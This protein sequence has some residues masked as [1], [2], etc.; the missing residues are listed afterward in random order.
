MIKRTVTPKI[1]KLSALYPVIAITGPR[2]S[3]KTTLARE[4]FSD[5][6]YLNLENLD[7]LLAARTDPRN[8][9]HLGSGQKIIIDEIQHLPDLFSYIQTEVDERKIPGQFVITGSQQFELSEKISQSLAGRVA[10]FTLL[11]L[12]ICELGNIPEYEKLAVDGFYPRIYDRPIPPKDYYRD[13]VSTY[14]ERDVRQIKN[15]GDLSSFQRFLQLVAG[16]VGQIVNFS[17]L[18]SDAGINHRTAESWLSILEASYI[19]F[20]LQPYFRNFGKRVIK[21]PKLYFYDTGLLCYLLGIDNSKGLSVHY[22]IGSIFENMII[23]DS[24]KHLCNE[25]SS[26]KLYFFRDNNGLE[27]DLIIDHN[28]VQKGIEIKSGRTFNS[29]ML[30]GL[31]TWQKL[32]AHAD[33]TGYLVYNGE[34]E[35]KMGTNKI[36]NWK[37]FV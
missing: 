18:A 31:V 15:I 26:D 36:V 9:L 11:P 12:S 5:Y 22:A 16:R 3:G 19:I 7:L 29:E 1:K 20:R 34:L 32:N 30:S 24:L 25:R 10:N 13:Y 23:A 17:S 37:S 8:F 27:L 2:Q 14:V 28:G 35:Q 6:L 21:S 4:I 33:K